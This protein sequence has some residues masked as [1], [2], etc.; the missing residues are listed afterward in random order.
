[1]FASEPGCGAKRPHF[2]EG[3]KSHLVAIVTAIPEEF[4]AIAK[5][6]SE[7]R[8]VRAPRDRRGFL[9]KG[10]MGGAAVLLA[11]TGDGRTR[12]ERGVSFLLGEFPVSLLVGAGAAG[13]LDPSLRA[14]EIVVAERL[15]DE[16]G[17]APP[18][19]GPLLARAVAL[20]ARPATF[21]TVARPIT[22][23]REKRET[24]VRFGI[25]DSS[26]AVVDMESAAWARASASRGIPFLALRAVSDSFEEDL[27]AFLSSCL[28]PEGSV[29]RAAVA[30]RLLLRP[31]ALP[32]LLRMRRR[33]REGA[34][35]LALFLERLLGEMI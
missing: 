14:G 33:V 7:G 24:A 16:E 15:V 31:A 28:T 12:A 17:E 21:V 18:P 2:P 6:V 20:G 29:D 34:E 22:S 8:R 11:M 5:F 25:P 23:S 4:E 27:P 1:M 26:G 35:A 19:D 9:L 3:R 10:R 13:A 32:A 30:R